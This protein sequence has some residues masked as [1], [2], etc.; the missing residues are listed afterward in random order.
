LRDAL[1][2]RRG[3]LSDAS[4]VHL[5]ESYRPI[6][7]LG[8]LA[9]RPYVVPIENA[10]PGRPYGGSSRHVALMRHPKLVVK[11]LEG[12]PS[13]VPG[14]AW[15]GT[16]IADDDFEVEQA[17]AASEPP[18]HD[19]WSYATLPQ[20]SWKRRY[21][22]IAL[23]RIGEKLDDLFKPA[24][25]LSG[26]DGAQPLAHL[27]DALGGLI[28][29]EPGPGTR[30]LDGQ[31]AAGRRGSTSRTQKRPDAVLEVNPKP[32]IVTAY[33]ETALRVR[34]KL[35]V[36]AQE[37]FADV[38]AVPGVAIN[39]GSYVEREPPIAATQPSILAWIVA[40]VG[41]TMQGSDSLR[42]EGQGTHEC[43]V[44]VSVPPDTAVAVE[45]KLKS[46]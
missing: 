25:V 8:L 30:S 24:P 1:A 29:Y 36:P 16:F 11:Y 31:R 46:S 19:N 41:E 9:I 6:K 26:T 14:T 21:V 43:A 7:S 27:G 17:F 35:T 38:M 18:S 37:S 44:L 4:D 40:G 33:G 22:R 23:N 39:D 10:E 2:T 5:I 3:K 12:P 20:R 28:A 15:A 34:F 42:V 13:P 32:D 45:L